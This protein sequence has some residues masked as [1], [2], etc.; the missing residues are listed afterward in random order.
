[1]SKILVRGVDGQN[2]TGT[3]TEYLSF[4]DD[5]ANNNEDKRKADYATVRRTH[6]RTRAAI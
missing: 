2:V 3:V 1:M 5:S 6:A 4:H